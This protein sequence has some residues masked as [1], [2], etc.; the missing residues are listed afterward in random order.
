M[1]DTHAHLDFKEFD[2][3]R[4]E[5]IQRAFDSGVKKI[6]NVGCNVER[7]K[8]S[9]R[10]AREY[11]Q[12]YASIGCHPHDVGNCEAGIMNQELRKLAKYNKVIAV[13]ECGLDYYRLE[14]EE[15]KIEQQKLFKMQIKLAKDLDLPLII[16][17]RDAYED[18]LEILKNYDLRERPGVTH[19]FLGSWEQAK[20]FLDLGFYVFFTGAITFSKKEKTLEAM[21]RIPLDKILIETDCPY[22]APEPKRGAR[23]EPAY[24]K[25]VAE[26]IAEVRGIDFAEAAKMTYNNS[27]K[28][29]NLK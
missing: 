8:A 17:C 3:D 28:L 10:L 11:E 24:V 23:N 22:L 7:S 21:K 9:V 4:A 27:V 13:G 18:L 25:Y 19:C 20:N 5:V 2:K 12:V 16:H 6:I 1:I 15:D 14:R 29:F 26:K